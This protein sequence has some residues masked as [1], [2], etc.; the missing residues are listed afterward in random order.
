MGKTR[1]MNWEN[2]KCV[3]KFSRKTWRERDRVGYL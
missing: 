2:K 1:S 3:Q